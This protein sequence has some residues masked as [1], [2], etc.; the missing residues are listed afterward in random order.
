MHG[1][2]EHAGRY[3]RL[4]ALLTELGFEVGA[5]DH[6]GH[7]KSDGKRGI[8][9][10]EHPLVPE[11]LSQI[12]LFA[13]ET[14]A[15][16]IVF[17]HSLGGLV[18][19]TAALEDNTHIAGLILSAPAL[20]PIISRIDRFKLNAL[21]TVAPFF[22]QDLGYEPSRLTQ[23]EQEWEVA[24][25]DPLIHGFKSA[26]LINWLIN[27]GRT[28]QESAKQ[29]TTPTLLLVP[30]DDPV[31]DPEQ[32]LMFAECVKPELL[33]LHRYPGFRHEIL[34]ETPD[35]RIRVHADIAQWL[36]HEFEPR[37]A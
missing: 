7:G 11:A 23:D 12:Q 4:V 21:N 28:A 9:E 17:G 31:I 30:E 32:T 25:S 19:L 36:C 1:V 20:V 18:A 29:L 24:R 8:I 15:Q 10:P 26:S 14:G 3:Q 6:P 34:N 5:H 37:S 35:R 33:V 2:G 27:A 13:E 16:P 22:V